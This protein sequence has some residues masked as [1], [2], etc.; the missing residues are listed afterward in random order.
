MSLVLEI[1]LLFALGIILGF[2]NVSS[3][4]GSF[5]S[6]PILILMGLDPSTANGTNRLSIVL[7]NFASART[8][9]KNKHRSIKDDLKISKWLVPAAIVGF[10]VSIAIPPNWFKFILVCLMATNCLLLLRP[11]EK[12]DM[13]G[14]EKSTKSNPLYFLLLVFTAVYGGFIQAGASFLLM[15]FLFRM[16]DYDLVEVNFHKAVIILIYTL[17]VFLLF[18]CFGLVH[19]PYAIGLGLGS[20]LGGA[21]ASMMM[22]KHG[23][24]FAKAMIGLATI[25]LLVAMLLK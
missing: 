19:W 11:K 5:I 10:Y 23:E 14:H 8:F 12:V 25:G 18:A 24:R 13:N 20:V 21:A 22:I 2:V 16:F 7:Q 9:Q 4:G 15:A 1:A 6:I 17:P 3:G